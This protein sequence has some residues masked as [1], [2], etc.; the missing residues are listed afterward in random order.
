M[1]EFGRLINR[2][3]SGGL[4]LPRYQLDR[5]MRVNNVTVT[6]DEAFVKLC[7]NIEGNKEKKIEV[8]RTQSL[9]E[10][11]LISYEYSY[12]LEKDNVRLVDSQEY[13]KR[14]L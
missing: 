11:E 13:H 4:P 5:N 8:K 6:P 1:V 9:P 3:L 12:L 14:E 10:Y 2:T 7:V